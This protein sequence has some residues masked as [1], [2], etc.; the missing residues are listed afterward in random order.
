MVILN[1]FIAGFFELN[2]VAIEDIYYFDSC[3]RTL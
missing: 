3:N 2:D 1:I